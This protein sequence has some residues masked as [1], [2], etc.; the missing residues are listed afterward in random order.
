MC[1]SL[2]PVR[3]FII[4][5]T[6]M[7]I[8]NINQKLIS[9]LFRETTYNGHVEMKN[10]MTWN[11]TRLTFK[12]PIWGKNEKS[13]WSPSLLTWIQKNWWILVKNVENVQTGNKN[14]K[15]AVNKWTV[16]PSSIGRAFDDSL[17]ALHTS[18]LPISIDTCSL[19]HSYHASCCWP[20]S[21]YSS[22]N[23]H[24]IKLNNDLDVPLTF[25]WIL[26]LIKLCVFIIKLKT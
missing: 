25:Y 19:T 23:F 24:K 17:K 12:L 3:S 22:V 8:A 20:I 9:N 4:T 26:L 18:L 11:P 7:S 1:N 14:V 5:S 13:K 16:T 2:F 15:L 6:T 10:H 21:A